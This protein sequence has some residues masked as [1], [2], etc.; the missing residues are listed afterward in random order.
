MLTTFLRLDTD[1]ASAAIDA[2]LPRPVRP[3]DHR[4]VRVLRGH[5]GR[6]PRQVEHA[7]APPAQAPGNDRQPAADLHL[8]RRHHRRDAGHGVHLAAGRQPAAAALA[9][10]GP[11]Q[12]PPPRAAASHPA[13]TPQTLLRPRP[14]TPARSRTSPCSARTART[15]ATRA[16]TRPPPDKLAYARSGGFGLDWPW[17]SEACAQWPGHGAED[18]YTGPWNRPT[19][20]T[21]LLLG[22]TG[23]TAPALPGCGRD[24]PRPGPR[25]PADRATGTGTPRQI[26]RAPAPRTTRSA[27]CRP[28]PSPRRAPSARRTQRRSPH[29]GQP[30]ADRSRRHDTPAP[31]HNAGPRPG[32]RTSSPRSRASAFRYLAG[33]GDQIHA[34]RCRRGRHTG[35]GPMPATSYS[36]RSCIVQANVRGLARPVHGTQNCT[37]WT[38]S[39][40]RSNDDVPTNIR[41]GAVAGWLAGWLVRLSPLGRL[42]LSPGGASWPPPSRPPPSSPSCLSSPTLSGWP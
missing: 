28:V 36:L 4:R 35:V 21:I 34:G 5:P 42:S 26:T 9:G 13:H 32:P 6:D 20:S 11:E 3:G 16:P 23:D 1:L 31:V 40:P 37:I 7:A 10:L 18:R 29:D 17:T 14:S 2:G 41:Q 39:S 15:R 22:N 33:N 19:A 25:A 27:T 38:Q 24:V 8:R 12:P 30:K